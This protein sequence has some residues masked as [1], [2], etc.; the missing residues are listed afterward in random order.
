[1]GEGSLPRLGHVEERQQVGE[2][3]HGG[4][5]VNFFGDFHH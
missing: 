3:P 5:G 2:G 1:M 4:R